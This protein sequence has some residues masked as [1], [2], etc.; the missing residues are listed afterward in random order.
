MDNARVGMA[1]G[2]RVRVPEL[3]GLRGLAIIAVVLYHA[4]GWRSPAHD[5]GH[6]ALLVEMT[7]VGWLGV[8]LFFVLSG[9]LITSIL[10]RTPKGKGYFKNFYLSRVFR[11]LPLYAVMLVAVF[12]LIPHSAKFVGLSAAFL[13]NVTPLFGVPIAYGV[14]WSLAVE[15]HFYLIWPWLV[16]WMSVPTLACMAAG[17]CLLEPLV[18]LYAHMHGAGVYAAS[19]YRFDGLAWGALLACLVIWRPRIVR[20]FG[21]ATVIL[22][23]LLLVGLLPFGVMTRRTD[24]GAALQFTVAQLLFVGIVAQ[25]VE[26]AGSVWTGPLRFRWLRWIG[27]I[28]YALYLIHFLVLREVGVIFP[29]LAIAAMLTRHAPALDWVIR[30]VLG[31]SVSLVL[32][33]LSRRYFDGPINR[34]KRRFM[35]PARPET[36]SVVSFGLETSV[37]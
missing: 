32:A 35:V 6:A 34:A 17:I 19:W 31:I 14:F 24:V 27:S 37:D 33:E 30:A 36:T 12:L 29:K 26:A 4:F 11:I 9:F 28:S 2:G 10:I 15:E 16:R 8:D 5:A 18:R 22:G 25:S 7:K 21:A 23:V 13:A 1:A 20:R 3:D